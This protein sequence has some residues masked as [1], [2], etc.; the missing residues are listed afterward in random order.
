MI[1][2][3]GQEVK[4]N[5]FK[6][7]IRKFLAKR[8]IRKICAEWPDEE[9]LVVP[10]PYRGR[11]YR[12]LIGK[13]DNCV[14]NR[15]AHEMVLGLPIPCVCGF[16]SAKGQLI[17]G[18]NKTFSEVMTQEETIAVFYHELGHLLNG[19][20]GPN[21]R[22]GIKPELDADKFACEAGY[23]AELTSALIK[24]RDA[25][26][27][28]GLKGERAMRD[29]ATRILAARKCAYREYLMEPQNGYTRLDPACYN[30]N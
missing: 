15:V 9:Y 6:V 11:I 16:P 30:L 29:M 12:L 23:S 1:F 2:Y 26:I 18:Y 3:T 13:Y 10:L 25:M 4:V 5:E 7:W 14:A 17:I 28:A 20:L 19:D 21:R 8:R 27:A 24:Y 22:R